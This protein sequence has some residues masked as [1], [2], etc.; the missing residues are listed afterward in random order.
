[1]QPIDFEETVGRIVERDPRYHREAYV[2]LRQGLD[3]CHKLLK[4]DKAQGERHVSV[5]QLLDGIRQYAL[6]TYGPMAITVLDEW[7]VRKCEDLG[8]I[9]FNMVEYR[10]LSTTEKDTREEFA[11]GFDFHEA[12]RVPFLPSSRRKPAA[13]P[14]GEVTSK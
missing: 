13:K 2:F 4:G 3:Y 10:L 11:A 9:V 7:G 8:D 14:E 6:Q 5:K 1:M 12:F